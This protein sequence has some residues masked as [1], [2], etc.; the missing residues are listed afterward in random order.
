MCFVEIVTTSQSINELNYFPNCDTLQ[1]RQPFGNY[2][3]LLYLYFTVIIFL[4]R[5]LCVTYRFRTTL[6]KNKQQFETHGF[7]CV[8]QQNIRNEMNHH[9]EEA[10]KVRT[11]AKSR[12]TRK[13]NEFVKAINDNKGIDFVKATF[14][15][16]RDAWSMVEGKHDLYTLFLTEE[17]V[18]QNEPWI[19]ELQELYSEG[20]V[21]HARYIEEH[22]QTD[23]KRIEGLS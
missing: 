13:W 5:L 7:G 14:A 22:S 9:G 2:S 15:Q 18:E 8:S 1:A 12:F 10:K 11:S 21:I 23:R 3:V 16:L 6:T 20:A 4:I 19:N 17:E